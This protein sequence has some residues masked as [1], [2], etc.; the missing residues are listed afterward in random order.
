MKAY[1]QTNTLMGDKLREGLN[2]NV[3]CVN[4]YDDLCN[5]LYE[6]FRPSNG[7]LSIFMLNKFC[8]TGFEINNEAYTCSLCHNKIS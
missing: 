1:R 3:I 6:K 7:N 8:F 2:K 4:C 5:H